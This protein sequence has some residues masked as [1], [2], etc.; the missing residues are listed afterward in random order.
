MPYRSQ[1]ARTPRM[2]SRLTGWPPPVLFVTVTKTT[3]TFS[4][5][6]LAMKA[7]RASRSMLP[8]NGCSTS[9]WVPSGMTK[10]AASAP[11][12]STLARVVSKWV[13]LGIAVPGPAMTLKRIF[14]AALPWW[15]GMTCRNG[16]SAW[17]DSRNRYHDGEP[18]YDSSPRMTPAHCS[19]DIAPVPES[20]RRSISTSSA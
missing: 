19:E 4:G 17:T 16:K 12:N 5:P 13:L 2:F 7:S 14:S 8:L 6:R 9:G 1:M 10:S 3:G 20:V 15:V 11:V 18:A